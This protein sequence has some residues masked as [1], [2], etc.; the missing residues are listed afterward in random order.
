MAGELS[1]GE[2]TPRRITQHEDGVL[3]GHDGWPS[4]NIESL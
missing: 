2:G 3:V 1:N 4:A